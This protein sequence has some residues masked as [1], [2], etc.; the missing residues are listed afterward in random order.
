M[1]RRPE[2]GSRKFLFYE[3]PGLN[4]NPPGLI[5]LLGNWFPDSHYLGSGF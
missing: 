5:G 1:P 4:Y 2:A 3:S